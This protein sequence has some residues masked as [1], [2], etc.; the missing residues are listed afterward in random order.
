MLV[1]LADPTGIGKHA[2]PASELLR[3]GTLVLALFALDS[4][5]AQRRARSSRA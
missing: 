4:L 5:L 1:W 3:L 2:L